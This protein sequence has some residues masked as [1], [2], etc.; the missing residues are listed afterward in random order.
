M[1]KR[2]RY[3][4]SVITLFSACLSSTSARSRSVRATVVT[5]IPFLTVTSSGRSR[6]DL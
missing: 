6:L 3:S 1:S 4:A 2:L 5:G